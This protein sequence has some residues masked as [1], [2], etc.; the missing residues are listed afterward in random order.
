MDRIKE[1]GLRFLWVP[2]VKSLRQYRRPPLRLGSSSVPLEL[3]SHRK[4]GTLSYRTRL[5]TV[6]ARDQVRF[7]EEML[8]TSD[9]GGARTV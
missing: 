2:T 7:R 6:M 9:G 5:Y 3:R 4:N 8:N 1:V